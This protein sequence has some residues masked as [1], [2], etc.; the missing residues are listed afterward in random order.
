MKKTTKGV[1]YIATGEKYIEEALISATSLKKHMPNLSVTLFSDIDVKSKY[2]D[3]VIKIKKPKY[4]FE[5]KVRCVSKSPYDRTLFLDTDTYICDDV[6][7]LFDLLD[8]FDMAIAHFPMKRE[9]NIKGIPKSFVLLDTGI[10]LFKK[11]LQVKTLFSEWLKLYNLDKKRGS[12]RLNSGFKNKFKLKKKGIPNA[13]IFNEIIY[14]NK[15]RFVTLTKEY[16]FRAKCGFVNCKVKILH[17]RTWDFGLIERIINSNH[18]PRVFIWSLGR[19]HV[20]P[21]EY[22]HFKLFKKLFRRFS[23]L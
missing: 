6:S 2:L 18:S 22:W 19:L 12:T 13:F 4:S 1:I 11:S 21:S 3:N 17:N 15:I 9:S 10:I 5:D 20:F 16:D 8:R 23:I 14:N 7:G